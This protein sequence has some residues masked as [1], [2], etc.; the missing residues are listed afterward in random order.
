MTAA[1]SSWPAH[2]AT[3][4]DLPPV[5]RVRPEKQPSHHPA[6]DKRG[7]RVLADQMLLAKRPGCQSDSFDTGITGWRT[8]AAS[9]S[10][11]VMRPMT[12][13]RSSAANTPLAF[14]SVMAISARLPNAL[15]FSSERSSPVCKLLLGSIEM[16]PVP[17]TPRQLNSGA[18]YPEQIPISRW[19]HRWA[20]VCVWRLFTCLQPYG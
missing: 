9:N 14:R 8:V 6:S 19:K 13:H 16:L 1:N 15:S 17:Q 18:D 3:K 7:W 2:G 11:L 10:S 5:L 4:V 12:S 20:K